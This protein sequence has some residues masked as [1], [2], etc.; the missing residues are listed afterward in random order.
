MHEMVDCRLR[1]KR[2]TMIGTPHWMAPETLSQ[3]GDDSQYDTKV[4]IWSLGITLIELAE[5]TPPLADVRSV[6]KVI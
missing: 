4:D 1:S 3:M 6:F 5:M 2:G